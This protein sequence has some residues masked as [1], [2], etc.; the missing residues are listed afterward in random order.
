MQTR[1]ELVSAK[2]CPFVQRSAILLEE[3]GAPYEVR[4]VD[5]ADKPAWFLEISPLGKVPLL[6]VDDEVL[7]ESA[8]INEFLDETL[9]ERMHPED[10]LERARHRAWIEV[11]SQLTVDSYRLMVAPDETA[12][13]EAVAAARGKLARLEDRVEGPYFAGERFRLVDTA[14]APALQRLSWSEEI[15]PSLGL[16]EGYP[17]VLAWRDRLLERPSVQRSLVP[18]ARALF[19]DYLMGRES[20]SRRRPKSWLG[21]ALG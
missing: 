9:G 21:R 18:E 2:L 17:K 20:P 12:A 7:F 11:L 15:E 8:V 3:K 13:R 4:Y 14:A 5:L 19:E 6:K 10:P 16:F 1:Y